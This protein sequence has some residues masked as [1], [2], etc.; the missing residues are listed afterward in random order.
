ML[1]I[2]GLEMATTS[3]TNA[4]HMDRH[5]LNKRGNGMLHLQEIIPG[6]N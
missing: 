5:N 4:A 2:L 1:N 6:P 3:T